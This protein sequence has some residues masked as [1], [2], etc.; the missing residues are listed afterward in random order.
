MKR[1]F[2]DT[3][4]ILDLLA[5]RDLFYEPIARLVTLADQQKLKL[6][7]SPISFTTVE[8]VLA[9][10]ESRK[11]AI[12]KL[13]RFSI[14][15]KVGDTNQETV[16]KSLNSDFSDFEDAMQYFCALQAECDV[17]ISRNASDFKKSSIPVMTADEF[18]KSQDA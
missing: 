16:D 6:F 18:L 12:A 9:K 11:S 8:Y 17:I 15:C 4:V 13:R 10:S 2:L 14:I 3:N 1:L 5:E 7:T